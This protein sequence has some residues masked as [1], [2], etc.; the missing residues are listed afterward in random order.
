M[1]KN[2]N[3]S[4]IGKAAQKRQ[5]L[6]PAVLLMFKLILHF[7][8]AVH[9]VKVSH[10]I[11]KD[12]YRPRRLASVL[13]DNYVESTKGECQRN[14]DSVIHIEGNILFGNLRCKIKLSV[15]SVGNVDCIQT[16]L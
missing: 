12:R 16:V 10:L 13:A 4:A 8:P 11:A 5:V 6:R 2:C 1:E 15:L 7:S 14:L 9:H 3:S